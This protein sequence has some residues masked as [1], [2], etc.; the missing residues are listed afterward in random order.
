MAENIYSKGTR[1]WFEDKDQT[2]I[3]AEVLSV[4]KGADDAIKLVFI[5]ERG[6]VGIIWILVIK[7]HN[8]RCLQEITIH[9]TGKDIKDNKSLPPLRNPP[10]LETADDLA[11]LSH[12]NEPSGTCA[13]LFAHQI[14]I[15]YK[16]FFIQFAIVTPSIVFTP[17]A[18]LYSLP[19][20]LFSA[21]LSMDL[22]LFKPTVDGGGES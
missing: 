19:S 6:K 12:L 10:L 2:W 18:E 13:M 20:I 11:T 15:N 5:D 9:T 16:Q 7:A 3:S 21:L 1:V 22:K 14:I 17:T 4:S 8:C